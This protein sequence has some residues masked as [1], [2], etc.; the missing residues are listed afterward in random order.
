MDGIVRREY[1]NA[2]QGRMM[3]NLFLWR[4]V[5]KHTEVRDSKTSCTYL[6]PKLC[7]DSNG[8]S[9]STLL[10]AEGEI[11]SKAIGVRR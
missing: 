10:C 8:L 4:I 9:F 7:N 2:K 6:H 3:N 5:S 1:L 11:E